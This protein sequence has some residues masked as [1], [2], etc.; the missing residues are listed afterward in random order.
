M[1]I[2]IDQVFSKQYEREVHVAYQRKGSKLRGTIRTKNGIKGLSTFFPKAGTGEAGTKG[3]HG[4]VPVM[5]VDHSQVECTLADYYAGDWVDTLDELKTQ[6]DEREV[7]V[8]A[9]AYALGRKT[10]SLIITTLATGSNSTTMTTGSGEAGFR[11]SVLLAIA[12][13]LDRD[14]PD[15]GDIYA[16]IGNRYW[17]WLMT[18]EEFASS[19]W[20]GPALPYTKAGMMKSWLG[21]NWIRHS[22][23]PKSS[24]DR[25]NFLYHRT[26]AGHAIGADVQT[27]IT[28]HGDRAAHFIN[29][30][31]SMG[32][33]LI[34][35][36]G[37][38]KMVLDESA[39]LPTS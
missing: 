11:N 16:A 24:N 13:L 23:L 1:S 20:T 39:A 36:N 26:A 10:D 19:D 32:T 14:V 6:I 31:M 25:T 5:N 30:M 35:G 3:R 27:D 34:D 2:S 22:G 12:A 7:L 17:A 28:W 15:D 37:V 21:V 33:A 29:N 9:G 8:N 18:I 38:Q 4:L